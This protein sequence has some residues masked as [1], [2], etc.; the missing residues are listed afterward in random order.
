MRSSG[1]KSCVKPSQVLYDGWWNCAEEGLQHTEG[2]WNIKLACKKHSKKKKEKKKSQRME[3]ASLCA[4]PST[5]KFIHVHVVAHC[6]LDYVPSVFSRRVLSPVSIMLIRPALKCCQ[7]TDKE[8]QRNFLWT[9]RSCRPLPPRWCQAPINVP[10]SWKPPRPSSL[11]FSDP[12]FSS[13]L[14]SVFL[15]S[16]CTVH[17]RSFPFELRRTHTYNFQGWIFLRNLK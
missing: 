8:P 2:K 5:H 12:N 3:R 4:L 10:P 6:V 1:V 7:P 17:A 9:C 15:S 11:H 16:A 14:L 13:T